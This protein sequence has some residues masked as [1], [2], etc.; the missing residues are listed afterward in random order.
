M[1]SATQIKDKRLLIKQNV[2][3][4]NPIQLAAISNF[5]LA[6]LTFAPPNLHSLRKTA[7][8]KNMLENVYSIT[9]PEYLQQMTRWQFF[10]PE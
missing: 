10:T 2:F 6:Q 3:S 4:Y 5:K 7:I 1:S 9:P 8:V